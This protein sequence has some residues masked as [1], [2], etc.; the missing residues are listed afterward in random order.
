MKGDW[1]LLIASVTLTLVLALGIIRWLAPA[2]LGLPI[3]LQ[4]VQISEKIPPFFKGVFREEDYLSKDFLLKDPLTSVRAKPLLREGAGVGPH[5]ILGFRNRNIPNVSDIVVIGDSQTYGN[6]VVLEDNWPNKMRKALHSKSPVTYSMAVGG[7]GAIQYLE[8][9]FNAVS[10]RPRIIIVAFYTG[11]DP[12][13]SYKMA[14]SNTRWK[15]LRP[16]AHIDNRGIFKIAFPTAPS[17]QWPV[18]FG[19]GIETIFTPKLRYVSNQ[20]HPAMIAGYD[21]M[22]KVAKLIST[23]AK[24]IGIK[25]A[26]TIIPT[27]E[28]VYWPK[29]EREG[30]EI[31]SDYL[32]LVTAEQSNIERLITKLRS[33]DN[34]LYIDTITSLQKSALTTD[35]LYPP[36]INGHPF[37]KGYAVIGDTM[38]KAIEEILP[39]IPNGIFAHQILKDAYNIYLL[40]EKKAWLFPSLELAQKNGWS[41]DVIP[42]IDERT[43]AT[44]PRDKID[45]INHDRFGPFYVNK[46]NA[47][48]QLH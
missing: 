11:N 10:F 39:N 32:K 42:K 29:I 37:E 2:L 24:N 4:M 26:F 12:S 30:I 43:L 31:N 47:I 6:N 9:F 14:Y 22:A 41:L 38:A 15:N 36:N 3:D 28:L 44:L 46:T 7:W 23:A 18:R 1:L 45:H 48:G 25:T 13:E 35:L 21:I 5:D 20:N 34:A 8:M 17:D 16:A 40:K 19:D 27:K 33:L